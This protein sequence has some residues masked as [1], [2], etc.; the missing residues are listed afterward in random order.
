MIAVTSNSVPIAGVTIVDAGRV[1]RISPE[2]L[3]VTSDPEL[4]VSELAPVRVPRIVE[5]N[6]RVGI[7]T[8][9]ETVAVVASEPVDSEKAAYPCPRLERKSG[10]RVDA[11]ISCFFIT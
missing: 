10:A 9:C 4:T 2:G 3:N 5:Y 1:T 7:V 6:G 11:I 8:I